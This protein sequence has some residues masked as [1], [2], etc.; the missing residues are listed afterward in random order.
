LETV[1][2]FVAASQRICFVSPVRMELSRAPALTGGDELA[3]AVPLHPIPQEQR[4]AAEIARK[5]NGELER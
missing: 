2:V 5:T 4:E 3:H 1:F